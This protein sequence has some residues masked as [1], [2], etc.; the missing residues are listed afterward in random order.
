MASNEINIFVRSKIATASEDALYICGNSD[1]IVA[2]DFDDEWSEFE[3]K[4]A[5]FSY[6]NKYTDVL[7]SGDTC[8]MPAISNTLSLKIGVFAGNLHTS[9]P[10]V[11]PAKKSIL[12]GGGTPAPPSVDVYSQILTMLNNMDDMSQEEIEKV[13]EEYMAENPLEAISNEE[14]EAIINGD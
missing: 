8:P 1:Y 6:G 14:I 9:T 3:N 10:A 12:C 7:F 13:I 4:T 2:F 5:R 11:I